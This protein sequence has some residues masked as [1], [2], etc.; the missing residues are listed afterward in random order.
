MST[1]DRIRSERAASAPSRARLRAGR[2]LPA[3]AL[4]FLAAD[5]GAKLVGAEAAVRG[6]VQLGFPPSATAPIGILLA[7]CTLLHTAPRT[8]VL[9]ALLLTGYLGGAVAIH[10]RA[11][12]GAF[13]ILF[14]VAFGAL[15]WLGLLLRRPA[16]AFALRERP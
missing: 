13:P 9:G 6:T 14:T 12:S 11:G 5:S 15:V 4:L 2:G 16:L 7:I 3:L 8:A 1:E 10:V